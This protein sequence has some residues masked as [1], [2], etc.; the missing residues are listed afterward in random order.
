VS[1]EQEQE[2]IQALC[3]LPL[4]IRITPR[5]NGGY[6]WACVDGSGRGPTLASV[7]AAGVSY[8]TSRLA[9]DTTVIDDLRLAPLRERATRAEQSE[10]RVKESRKPITDT[11]PTQETRDAWVYAFC[12]KGDYP[13][14]TERC[15]KWLIFCSSTR[16][17]EEWQRIKHAVEQGQL[18]SQAKVS[19][20]ASSRVRRSGQHVICV[21]T[22]D[23]EDSTD[24]RRIRQVLRDLG[25]TQKLP[26]KS[27][28]ETLNGRYGK[29]ATSIYN[30]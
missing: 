1:T 29:D 15:G 13:E 17:D 10:A 4:S 27:D 24:A 6:T 8:L 7:I 2:I 22:Y 5:K 26:Y 19:T 9:G 3:T 11:L 20:A 16:I 21:Y 23:Y 14:H 28:E 12:A 18:G 25:F 30:E